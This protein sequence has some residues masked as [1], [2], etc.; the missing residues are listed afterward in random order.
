LPSFGNYCLLITLFLLINNSWRFLIDSDTGWHVRT[1]EW[2]FET[3][4]IP[5]HDSFSHTMAGREWFA[6]EWLA[7]VAMAFLHRHWGLAGVVGA[8]ALILLASYAALYRMMIRRRA[9][10]IV[11][12]VTTIFVALS[13]IVHW[14]ARPHV[15][16]IVLMVFW[17]AAVE[18]FRRNRSRWI[19]FLPLGI[20]LWANLHGA[21]VATFPT[22]AAYAIGE[23]IEFAARGEWWNEKL[24]RVLRVYGIVG[25]L[26]VVA[27]LAT[28]YGF[29]LYGHLWGYLTDTKLL[30]SISEFQSPNFHTLDGKMIEILLF[31]GIVAAVN[32]VRRRQFVES[33][34]LMFW[35]HMA[36]QSERHITLASVAFAPIIA[37]QWSGLIAEAADRIAAG[38]GKVAKALRAA[39]DW[40][41]ATIAIDRQLTGAFVSVTMF[42]FVIAMTGSGLAGKLLPLQFNPNRFPAAA[43]D[44]ILR[45]N[46][47]GKMYSS[48]QFGGYLIYRLYPRFKVFLDGRS[49]FYRQG[50]VLD[51]YDKIATV[52]PQWAGLLDKYDV[53][54][55]TLSPDEPLA[56]I[57][58]ASGRWQSVYQDSVAQILIRKPVRPDPAV[59]SLTNSD[60]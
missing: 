2:I 4:M 59:N 19:Y 34:V 1:G 17:L 44:F 9:D 27:A 54:W 23:W 52:K 26:S 51:D 39:R 11:A 36:L 29:R 35:G 10:E 55:M 21:F 6:W 56:L 32:A 18:D 50:A 43:A 41:R 13:G 45:T 46:P 31:L 5:R 40:Y 8:A 60:K 14:L 58:L 47:E 20:A 12:F 53:Q 22:L 30:S 28:P 16:S 25:A 57:A 24:R 3:R 33:L 48:D 7:D 49:D 37:E 42:A 15:V 38:A